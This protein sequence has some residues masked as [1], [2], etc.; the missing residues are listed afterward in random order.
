MAKVSNERYPVD[1]TVRTSRARVM[2]I[3]KR[4]LGDQV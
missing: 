4:V 2:D 1:E 3:A